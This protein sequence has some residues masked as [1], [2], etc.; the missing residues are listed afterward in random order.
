MKQPMEKALFT[1]CET[2]LERAEFFASGRAYATGIVAHSVALP[3]AEAFRT[4]SAEASYAS[5]ARMLIV[6]LLNAFA[7]DGFGAPLEDGESELVD[8][9]RAFLGA[10]R[11]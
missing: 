3:I 4:A 5:V 2:D 11:P 6:D 10:A 8:R 7:V 9:A 1:D